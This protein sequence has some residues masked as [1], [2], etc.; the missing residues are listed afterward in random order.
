MV[1]LPRSAE[2]N[3]A[4][5][6]LISMASDG[7][8]DSGGDDTVEEGIP[9]SGRLSRT[10]VTSWLQGLGF[11]LGV[12]YRAA[13][14]DDYC[15]MEW[16][17]NYPSDQEVECCAREL[18][19]GP[20]GVEKLRDGIRQLNGG[21]N[22]QS[23]QAPEPEPEPEVGWWQY[24]NTEGIWQPYPVGLSV[25]LDE[26][27]REEEGR[28]PPDILNPDV[29][30]ECGSQWFIDLN[31]MRQ[32]R[33]GGTLP[34][35]TPAA[36]RLCPVRCEADPRAV[37]RDTAASLARASPTWL[38]D[39]QQKNCMLCSKKFGEGSIQQWWQKY[40]CR[41]C[42]WVVCA[43]CT[44]FN[45]LGFNQKTLPVDRWISSQSHSLRFARPP[46]M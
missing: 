29:D 25:R 6:V 32:V 27:L 7:D 21:T 45:T 10:D 23:E 4:D 41:Y 22:T 2:R 44:P 26:R 36:V 46:G 42:G 24:Q 12:Q 19:L 30:S 40:P 1:R 3:N 5:A 35:P 16:F 13:V 15:E 20:E 33:H 9:P 28:M 17:E 37:P 31:Q 8:A 11:G 34:G 14:H 18:Q 38:D 43:E 39:K